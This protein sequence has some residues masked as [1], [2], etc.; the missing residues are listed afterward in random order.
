MLSHNP[1]IGR[2]N[3]IQISKPMTHQEALTILDIKEKSPSKEMIKAQFK[4]LALLVHPDKNPQHD[5]KQAEEACKKLFE[6]HEVANQGPGLNTDPIDN[7]MQDFINQ[8]FREHNI[9]WVAGP[10]VRKIRNFFLT[11]INVF[12]ADVNADQAAQK[13]R[14][15][16]IGFLDNTNNPAVDPIDKARLIQ[17]VA[18]FFPSRDASSDDI[19]RECLKSGV[20]LTATLSFLSDCLNK[21]PSFRN[22][23]HVL[24]AQKTFYILE[25]TKK[26][27]LYIIEKQG[28]QPVFINQCPAD[29]AAFTQQFA[30]YTYQG[31]T[32]NGS[33]MIPNDDATNNAFLMLNTCIKAQPQLFS[34]LINA[35]N[36]L[37]FC[38]AKQP[39]VYSETH[40]E[41][42]DAQKANNIDTFLI[43]TKLP[44]LTKRMI[45]DAQLNHILHV[46]LGDYHPLTH[47][48]KPLRGLFPEEYNI[49]KLVNS[50]YVHNIHIFKNLFTGEVVSEKSERESPI[51]NNDDNR[52]TPVIPSNCSLSLLQ[53]YKNNYDS[54]NGLQLMLDIDG[55]EAALHRY[56]GLLKEFFV[57][58]VET[59]KKTF[60]NQKPQLTFQQQFSY[61][62]L[63][64]VAP[65]LTNNHA[66]T[67]PTPQ[68]T[69]TMPTQL[70]AQTQLPPQM[71]KSTQLPAP[72]AQ[73]FQS[74][75][76]NSHNT[77]AHPRP[78]YDASKAKGIQ[79]IYATEKEAES[80]YNRLSAN[81]RQFIKKEG[82][83]IHIYRSRGGRGSLGVFESSKPGE[84]AICFPPNEREAFSKLFSIPKGAA[85]CITQPGD[86][87]SN[88]IYF[89]TNANSNYLQVLQ[90]NTYQTKLKQ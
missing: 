51:Y 24:F 21:Y 11:V 78:L 45:L 42:K 66:Y 71:Q 55:K 35:A 60:E 5:S 86:H 62:N 57:P 7:E 89:N 74:S 63:S 16:F 59:I 30:L 65:V 80:V 81:C 90:Q 76:A 56:P 82:S 26:A 20:N 48:P 18:L 32:P 72:H 68:P 47:L 84:V 4:K 58:L 31:Q 44:G 6:A 28:L 54:G 53:T 17:Y 83:A 36:Y 19:A 23:Y 37:R 33:A 52:I 70:P 22:A 15:P 69:M 67:T 12:D 8:L 3:D 10:K 2:I 79:Y 9:F 34:D 25:E 43:K 1:D 77:I 49:F 73:L 14:Q 39:F 50:D 13:I 29:F 88:I 46:I 87:R 64:F 40:L 85:L 27:L 75:Y 41:A 38:F 61:S